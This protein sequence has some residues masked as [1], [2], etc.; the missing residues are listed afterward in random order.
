MAKRSFSVATLPGFTATAII[1][2][3]ALYLP[4]FTLT[5]YSFNSNVSVGV[6]GEFSFNWYAKAWANDHVKAATLRSLW[7]AVCA[8]GIAT[9]AATLAALGTTRR[10]AFK[11][12]TFIY[13]MINQPLMV[14]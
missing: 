8:S 9:T 10:K 6:W 12:Q 2:F 5:A 11:G 1:V 7:I 13:V 14:P 3:I 4:I